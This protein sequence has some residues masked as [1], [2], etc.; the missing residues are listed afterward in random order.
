MTTNI[1]IFKEQDGK[2]KNA[3]EIKDCALVPL[4]DMLC[5]SLSDAYASRKKW[6]FPEYMDKKFTV[7]AENI[8]TN[9][10]S[11]NLFVTNMLITNILV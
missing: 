10:C 7:V 1:N 5:G 9:S 2:D 4:C 6:E 3:E 8:R 11:T